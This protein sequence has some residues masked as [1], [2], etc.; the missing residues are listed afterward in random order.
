MRYRVIAAGGVLLAG[1]AWAGC[2]TPPPCQIIPKQLELI[3]YER[4]QAR[5]KL[6]AKKTEVLTSQK[7]LE[8]AQDRLKQ[9]QDERESLQKALGP[10]AADTTAAG[11]KP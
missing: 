8:L 2:G 7:N 3:R 5:T 11:R 10:N 6:E 9:M 4:D 1:L